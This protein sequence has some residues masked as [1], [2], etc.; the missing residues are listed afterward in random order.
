[1]LPPV[2]VKIF[3][4]VGSASGPDGR[5][6]TTALAAWTANAAKWCCMAWWILPESEVVAA[7]S[8]WSSVAL[9]TRFS[10]WLRQA[11]SACR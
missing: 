8:M 3:T 4:R 9:M 6:S 10:K 11:S 1:M 7:A 2:W 5:C